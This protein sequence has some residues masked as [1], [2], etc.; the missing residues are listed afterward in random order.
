MSGE[1]INTTADASPSPRDEIS[2]E[3]QREIDAFIRLWEDIKP[4]IVKIDAVCAEISAGETP[5]QKKKNARAREHARELARE[6]NIRIEW[7]LAR[8][9]ANFLFFD[10]DGV[11]HGTVSRD[12]RALEYLVAYSWAE[13]GHNPETHRITRLDAKLLK[14]LAA[15]PIKW[16]PALQ[17]TRI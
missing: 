9:V 4:V 6:N 8:Y 12:A 15:R 5:R 11:L 2:P 1:P 10:V 17:A 3:N 13:L 16:I 7:F 14:D